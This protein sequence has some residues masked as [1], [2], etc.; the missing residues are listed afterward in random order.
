[1]A[2]V[3]IDA[4]GLPK[5]PV[6][7]MTYPQVHRTGV[8]AVDASDPADA[9]AGVDCS[10]FQNCRFDVSVSATGLQEL[11]L[12]VLFWNPRQGRWF[13]GAERTLY[14]PGD[15]SLMVDARGSVVF[16]KVAGFTGSSFTLSADYLLS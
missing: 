6:Y 7:E 5:G 10:G 12:Q 9:S 16:L 13:V 1:M 4:N 11:R 15:Y 3:R 14:S 8:T 2:N